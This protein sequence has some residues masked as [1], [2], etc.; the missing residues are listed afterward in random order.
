MGSNAG[1]ARTTLVFSDGSLVP[2][3]QSALTASLE[4]RLSPRWT[5]TA[6]GGGI[7]S[8]RLLAAEG[9]VPLGPGAVF[10]LGASWLALESEGLRPFVLLSGSL[11]F[12][13]LAAAP[14]GYTAG[15]LRLSVTAGYTLFERFSPYV[16]ARAFGGPV[17]WRGLQG[18][19][20]YH[21]QLGAGLAVGLPAGVD[22]LVEAVPLGE[23]RL[24]AGV[25]LSF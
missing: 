22:V 7:L 3:E 19:D 18:T 23:Q 16:T 17:F 13:R 6:A 4:Y 8:G 20:L 25:G 24:T 10:S 9:P 14:E 21:Y 15:D 12:T 2:L 1:A 11:A 5:L